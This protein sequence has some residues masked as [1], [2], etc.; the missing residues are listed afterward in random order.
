MAKLNQILAIE[1]NKKTQ[2]YAEIGELHKAVQK[3]DLMNGFNKVYQPKSEDSEVF[4][5]ESKRVQYNFRD[6]F[7]QICTR[8]VE[9][10]D[11]TATKDWSNCE[12]RANIIIDN[13][14]FL[15]NVPV[16]YLLFLEKQLNDLR[17]IVDQM[18]E[19]DPGENWKWDPEAGQHRTEPTQTQKTKKVQRPIVMYDATEKHP[20]QTQLITDD[21]I[22]GHWSTTKFSG[23]IPKTLKHKLLL[24]IDI[25][26]DAVKFAREHA[27]NME[28]TK[29][30]VG[31][32]ILEYV[33]GPMREQ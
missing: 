27:N 4:P 8:T 12:A 26:N 6:V 29:R 28:A 14:A 33:F 3:P 11:I 13:V 21:V 1:K 15:E 17:T 16:T 20:A 2:I 18:A 10:F 32:K 31:Q 22:I 23:A 25:L 9:F 7:A 19:L 5:P 30:E 24:R